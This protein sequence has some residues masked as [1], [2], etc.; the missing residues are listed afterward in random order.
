MSPSVGATQV[1]MVRLAGPAHCVWRGI[2]APVAISRTNVLA[3]AARCQG[4]LH[5]RTASA[6]GAF[7][8][9]RGGRASSVQRAR[10]ARGATG[11][12]ALGTRALK[13]VATIFR[14]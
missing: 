12:H 7:R 6:T 1:G 5:D 10:S 4:A 9:R 3:T 11:R 14:T 2:G 13:L 8:V